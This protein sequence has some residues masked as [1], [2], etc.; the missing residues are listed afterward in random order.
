[1]LQTLNSSTKY[2]ILLTFFIVILFVLFLFPA[3]P[4]HPSYNIFADTRRFFGIRNFFDVMSNLPFSLIGIIGLLYLWI[5]NKRCLQA[6][7]DPREKLFYILFFLG[8]LLLGPG[9]AYYHYE[10]SNYSLLYDRIPITIAFMSVFAAMLAERINF[11]LGYYLLWP[12]V[13]LGISTICYWYYSEWIGRGDLRPY[14]A[15]QLIPLLGIPLVFL[16]YSAPYTKSVYIL[17][18]ITCYLLAKI[19]EYFD[20]AIFLTTQHGVSGHTLKHLLAGLGALFI[21]IYL[22]Q[23]KPQSVFS[24]S[25]NCTKTA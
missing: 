13:L 1:M 3:T 8:L 24:S 25:Q 11:R 5:P 23:R 19:A 18:A 14:I 6:F 10:I 2:I 20:A 17:V 22:L 21:L 4:Q 15:I 9:S 12:L 7:R 16:L